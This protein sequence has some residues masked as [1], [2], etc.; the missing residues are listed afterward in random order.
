MSESSAQRGA[1]ILYFDPNRTRPGIRTL[2]GRA[3][4]CL[5]AS[6]ENGEWIAGDIGPDLIRT[7]LRTPQELRQVADDEASR[8]A[9]HGALLALQ[10]IHDGTWVC[11][12]VISIFMNLQARALETVRQNNHKELAYLHK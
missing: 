3:R 9:E 2:I 10:A 8:L 4:A 5:D 12:N 11:Q 6:E 1:C 7:L